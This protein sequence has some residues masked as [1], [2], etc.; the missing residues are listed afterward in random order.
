M[1]ART[2]HKCFT[3]STGSFNLYTSQFYSVFQLPPVIYEFTFEL[4]YRFIMYQPLFLYMSNFQW[5][6]IP[7]V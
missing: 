7:T 4:S 6:L 3:V 1:F 2:T 5:F